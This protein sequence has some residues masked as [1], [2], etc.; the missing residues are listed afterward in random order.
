MINDALLTGRRIVPGLFGGGAALAQAVVLSGEFS[1]GL[2]IALNACA[3]KFLELV[4]H[5]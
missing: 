1:A 4:R 3:K 2:A 5:Y